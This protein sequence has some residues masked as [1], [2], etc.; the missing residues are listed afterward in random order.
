MAA[1]VAVA[2]VV[3]VDDDCKSNRKPMF[4]FHCNSIHILANID[5]DSIFNCVLVFFFL[6]FAAGADDDDGGMLHYT[7]FYNADG[8]IVCDLFLSA[9]G[10]RL[11]IDSRSH[12]TLSNSL[13]FFLFLSL[14]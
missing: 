14:I 2:V 6:L 4:L 5:Y 3:V 9:I 8:S 13:F 12:E 7:R 10:L 1:V 11:S